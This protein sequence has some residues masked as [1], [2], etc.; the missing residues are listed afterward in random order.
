MAYDIFIW[1]LTISGIAIVVVFSVK[2]ARSGVY[3]VGIVKKLPASK[4]RLTKAE[5]VLQEIAALRRE[6][7][8][9]LAL[10]RIYYAKK[11]NPRVHLRLREMQL[12]YW[13]ANVPEQPNPIEQEERTAELE[14]KS[15][16]QNEALKHLEKRLRQLEV[17]SLQESQDAAKESDQPPQ[18]ELIN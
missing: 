9:S 17:K 6:S 13:K 1:A 14:K 18:V 2:I 3:P 16:E 5:L 4:Q 15:V 8:R 11:G 7:V 10:H 12:A